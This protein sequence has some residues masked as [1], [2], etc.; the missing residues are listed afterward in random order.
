MKNYR[1]ARQALT[2]TRILGKFLDSGGEER[3]LAQKSRDAGIEIIVGA[4][5]NIPLADA[6]VPPL[7]RARS[8]ARVNG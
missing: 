7:I 8:L 5:R 1:R 2:E 4:M 3:D 6:R